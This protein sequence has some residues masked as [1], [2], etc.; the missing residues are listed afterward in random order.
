MNTYLSIFVLLLSFH[1]VVCSVQRLLLVEEKSRELGVISEKPFSKLC[2]ENNVEAVQKLLKLSV[3]DSSAINQA[4]FSAALNYLSQG[5]SK[6]LATLLADKRLDLGSGPVIRA[7]ASAGPLL[8][9]FL[10]LFNPDDIRLEK[11]VI[12][13]LKHGHSDL[14]LQMGNTLNFVQSVIWDHSRL[15]G[16]MLF[17][18]QYARFIQIF[19]VS[20]V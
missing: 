2:E 4:C 19:R 15:Q 8:P 11:V 20:R 18:R 5:Q 1:S 9:G 12:G 10:S 13:A 6:L 3:I 7:I 14:A 16:A 17:H